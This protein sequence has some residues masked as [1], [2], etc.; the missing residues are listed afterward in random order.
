MWKNQ[1]ESWVEVS[2][3]DRGRSLQ[4]P[5]CLKHRY[6]QLSQFQVAE[7]MSLVEE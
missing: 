4:V 2:R 5:I 3:V 7:P 6:S 1:G